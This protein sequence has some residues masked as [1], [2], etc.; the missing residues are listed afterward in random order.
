MSFGRKKIQH[1]VSKQGSRFLLIFLG[2]WHDA[3]HSPVFGTRINCYLSYPGTLKTGM[4]LEE[5]I[6]ETRSTSDFNLRQPKLEKGILIFDGCRPENQNY[7][8]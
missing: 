8:Y 6:E 5:K 4:R 3:R 7:T 1:Q 2:V